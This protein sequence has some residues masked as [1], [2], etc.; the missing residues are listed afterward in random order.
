MYYMSTLRAYACP[1]RALTS[2][3]T[4]LSFYSQTLHTVS[5]AATQFNVF[6]DYSPFAL[7]LCHFRPPYPLILWHRVP[8]VATSHSQMQ[9]SKWMFYISSYYSRHYCQYQITNWWPAWCTFN[10]LNDTLPSRIRELVDS[11]IVVIKAFVCPPAKQIVT[12]V[13]W[14]F[15][16]L[17]PV[18]SVVVCAYCYCCYCCVGI[19]LRR[20]HVSRD[21]RKV[22]LLVQWVRKKLKAE[23]CGINKPTY[24][25]YM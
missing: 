22:T 18:V 9:L 2:R 21:D 8:I 7:F 23:I 1:L 6:V 5:F 10:S 3:S 15:F 24:S 16:V 20:T 25:T 12:K 14:N 13:S 19:D 11:A 17:R 4:Y